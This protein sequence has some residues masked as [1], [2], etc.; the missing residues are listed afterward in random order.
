MRRRGPLAMQ[1]RMNWPV[2]ALALQLNRLG[3]GKKRLED[4]MPYEVLD[5]NETEI[6]LTTAMETWY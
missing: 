3:G 2:A 5:D 6:D 4:F 1:R